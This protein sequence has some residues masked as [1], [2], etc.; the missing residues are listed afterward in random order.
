V[1]PQPLS[2]DGIESAILKQG[3]LAFVGLKAPD[4]AR[5]GATG[6][7]TGLSAAAAKRALEA[8][9]AIG[10]EV[11]TFYDV[12][13]IAVVRI[14]VDRVPLLDA[15]SFVDFLEAAGTTPSVSSP[16]MIGQPGSPQA[17]AIGAPRAVTAD[18]IPWG[19]SQVNAPAA[20][21]RATGSGV[22]VM[23]LGYGSIP[24]FDNPSVPPGN[25]GGLFNA[26]SSYWQAGTAGMG[27]MLARE[28]GQ[29]VIGVAK[30]VAASHTY[31]WRTLT[32]GGIIDVASVISGLSQAINY[33]IKVVLSDVSHLDFIQAEANA[34]AQAWNYGVVTVSEVPST[35]NG[36][37]RD[38]VYPASYTNVVGVSGVKDDGQFAAGPVPD[39]NAAS[40]GSDYGPM[41]D[42]AGAF[43]SYTTF[44]NNQGQ[45]WFADS[46]AN[47]G[48]C[49]NF[50][51]AAHVAGVVAL[52]RAY[53]PSWGP[54]PIVQA[55]KQTASN[56]ASPNQ[57]IGYGI[58]NANAAL[59]YVLP[60]LSVTI[61]G[62]TTWPAYSTVT[63]QA[64]SSG[65]PP[66]TYAWKVNGSP[67]CGNQ[68]WCSKT[69]GARGTSVYFYVTVTDA[70]GYQG[71]DYHVVT[72]S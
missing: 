43:W 14:S 50:M 68:N 42:V 46:R 21:S 13:G 55:L 3:G 27:N 29:G 40:A 22:K 10:A 7:R 63:V 25:C 57:Q 45:Q 35:E 53:H 39:C 30:G 69:M 8:V 65:R 62:P 66:F 1:R 34:F 72:A 9:V 59:N 20:W 67:Y 6:Y 70:D 28:N 49:Y 51:A 4:S 23:L 11:L 26:C 61:Q 5:S 16:V 19:V 64:F 52:L 37:F 12:F 31:V 2:I 48:W 56:H 54:T 36:V 32:D 18:V 15:S 60:P 44:A 71:S 17:A 33:G 58:P 41:V 47:Y 38:L 24:H